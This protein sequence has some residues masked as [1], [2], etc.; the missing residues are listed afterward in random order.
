MVPDAERRESHRVIGGSDD[1]HQPRLG[2]VSPSQR[3]KL[4]DHKVAQDS[5]SPVGAELFDQG[6]AVPAKSHPSLKTQRSL[7]FPRCDLS[8]PALG[9]QAGPESKCQNRR[10][11]DIGRVP[12]LVCP[13]VVR[14]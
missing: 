2:F 8:F 10:A 5:T 1:K 14:T 9:K 13:T 11:F 4:V 6:R 3:R 7:W 12:L